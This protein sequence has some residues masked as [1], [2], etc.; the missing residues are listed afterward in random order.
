M[1]LVYGLTGRQEINF[2]IPFLSQQGS[3]VSAMRSPSRW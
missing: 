3:A 2:E 1:E